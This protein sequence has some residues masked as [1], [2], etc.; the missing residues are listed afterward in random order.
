MSSSHLMIYLQACSEF[1]LGIKIIWKLWTG[2]PFANLARIQILTST[3]LGQWILC[4]INN[5]YNISWLK[6]EF[7]SCNNESAKNYCCILYWE[8]VTIR[9]SPIRRRLWGVLKDLIGHTMIANIYR[10]EGTLA[11]VVYILGLSQIIQ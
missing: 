6:Y 1:I 9:Q 3:G 7:T 2:I 4:I 11:Q 8:S 5:D 10:E